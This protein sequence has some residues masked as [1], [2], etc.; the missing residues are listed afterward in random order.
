MFRSRHIVP[1][2]RVVKGLWNAY[3]WTDDVD[4]LYAEFTARGA[5][6]DY[7]LDTKDYGVREFGVRDPDGYDLAFGQLWEA[8]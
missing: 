2:Y 1:H 8:K 7:H 6:L 5:T 3:F 4:A